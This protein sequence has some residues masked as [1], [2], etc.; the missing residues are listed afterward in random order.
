MNNQGIYSPRSGSQATA[1]VSSPMSVTLS[2]QDNELND[3]TGIIFFMTYN[4][5][6][7][8]KIYYVC[9][10]YWRSIYNNL[11]TTYRKI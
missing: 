4:F 1:S 3:I 11:R 7:Y 10:S 5:I 9:L 2:L 6:L 8:T